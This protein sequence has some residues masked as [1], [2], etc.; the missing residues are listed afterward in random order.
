MTRD[1]SLATY[2]LTGSAAVLTIVVSL[3][4]LTGVTPAAVSTTAAHRATLDKEYAHCQ[5]HEDGVDCACFSQK[6]GH[7]LSFE[8]PRVFG[9]A[10][11]NKTDLARGQ[12]SEAC[13]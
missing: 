1:F 3:P 2:V 5:A 9:Y 6:S 8:T 7:I 10:Y 12:A 4:V 13:S 11:G